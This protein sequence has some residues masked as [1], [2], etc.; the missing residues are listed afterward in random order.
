MF[1]ILATLAVICIGFL[2]LRKLP[3]EPRDEPATAPSETPSEL[4]EKLPLEDHLDLH[5]VPPSEVGPL[6]DAYVEEAQR[7]GF[8][9]VRLIHG[10]GIGAL[11]RTVR[12]HL[13]RNPRVRHF[14]DAPPPS[15]RGATVA[16]LHPPDRDIA[17]PANTH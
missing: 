2:V 7:L 17:T 14:E 9:W 13:Q 4:P 8:H 15:G 12:V 16:E 3:A 6:V 5:G 1:W 11:R 10:R